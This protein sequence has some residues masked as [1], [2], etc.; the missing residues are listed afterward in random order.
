MKR[1]G[2]EHIII[3]MKDNTLKLEEIDANE[4][5]TL[6]DMDDYFGEGK[7]FANK[8]CTFAQ[9]LDHLR[10]DMFD[11]DPGIPTKE[12]V[13]ECLRGDGDSTKVLVT[14]REGQVYTI[15]VE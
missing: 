6:I 3:G 12:M 2:N 8:T 5:V 7:P 1:F 15:Y 4:M 11:Y 14:V 13:S 10:H 9:F